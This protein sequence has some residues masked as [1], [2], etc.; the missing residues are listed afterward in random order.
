MEKYNIYRKTLKDADNSIEIRLH[1]LEE[2]IRLPNKLLVKEDLRRFMTELLR[3]RKKIKMFFS[4]AGKYY[5]RVEKVRS[6]RN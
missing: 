6:L 4:V 1:C 5:L 3:E 2:L